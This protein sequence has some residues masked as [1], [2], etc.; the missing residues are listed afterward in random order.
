LRFPFRL[1]AGVLSLMCLAVAAS[2]DPVTWVLADVTF[3]DGGTASGMFTF[4]PDA[5]TACSTGMSPCGTY[6]AVDITTTMGTSR[7]GATY[8]FVCGQDDAACTVVT[9]DST[10]VLFLT[11]ASTDQTGNPGLALFFTGAGLYPP[12]GLGDQT[13]VTIDISNSSSSVGAGQEGTCPDPGCSSP[14][15]PLR[16]TVTGELYAIPEPTTGVLLLTGVAAMITLS[17]R[18]TL[19]TRAPRS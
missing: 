2:A 13:N 8:S 5:G 7:T 17:R 6:S 9:P 16:A 4:D 12:Q 18:R 1:I 15:S 10:E 19:A 11:S 3:D 14:G